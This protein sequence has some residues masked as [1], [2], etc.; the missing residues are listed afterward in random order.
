MRS[1]IILCPTRKGLSFFPRTRTVAL[2]APVTSAPRVC[3]NVCSSVISGSRAAFMIT[4][5]P[6]AAQA[7]SMAFSVAPTLGMGRAMPAP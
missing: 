1:G 4:V 3:K 2:P 5:S 7:A 6:S